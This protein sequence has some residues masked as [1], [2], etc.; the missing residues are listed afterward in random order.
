MTAAR[1]G[2]RAIPGPV[3]VAVEMMLERME[4]PK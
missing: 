3:M 4:K 1:T 2:D